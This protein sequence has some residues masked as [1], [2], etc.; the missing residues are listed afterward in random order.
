MVCMCGCVCV[1]VVCVC[2]IV[3][4]RERESQREREMDREERD[5]Y[6]P[7]ISSLRV[8][9]FDIIQYRYVWINKHCKTVLVSIPRAL[10]LHKTSCG[11]SLTLKD[12]LRPPLTRQG[13]W[14]YNYWSYLPWL[15]QQRVQASG[16]RIDLPSES[17]RPACRASQP[18]PGSTNL[19]FFPS[20][21]MEAKQHNKTTPLTV[22]HGSSPVRDTR[23]ESQRQTQ[24]WDSDKHGKLQ[25]L[26]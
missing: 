25:A 12:Q 7:A 26:R 18:P 4:E 16:D 1:C 5:K 9:S 15:S 6:F 23:Q 20:R 17:I 22:R 13:L 24:R 2:V 3:F 14:R 19:L 10:F 21:G 11:I 8:I